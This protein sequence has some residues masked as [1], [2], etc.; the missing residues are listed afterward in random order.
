MSFSSDKGWR[1]GG[2]HRP[3]AGRAD[4]GQPSAGGRNLHGESHG[5]AG[6][7]AGRAAEEPDARRQG[8]RGEEPQQGTGD[9]GF[10][11][12]PPQIYIFTGNIDSFTLT[13]GV[14]GHF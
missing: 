2:R 8:Q 14:F 12:L 3:G 13:K 9:T 1:D 4:Q 6:G 10:L 7:S 11:F 5:A